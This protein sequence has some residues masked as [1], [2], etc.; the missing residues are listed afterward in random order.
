[1]IEHAYM[2]KP[3]GPTNQRKDTVCSLSLR[4]KKDSGPDGCWRLT[5]SLPIRVD[6]QIRN[7]PNTAVVAENSRT[8]VGAEFDKA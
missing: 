2:L 7:F 6:D 1:M 3:N 8:T 5:F 4:Y